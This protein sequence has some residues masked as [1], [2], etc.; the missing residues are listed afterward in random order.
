VKCV[1]VAVHAIT[2]HLQVIE[3][4]RLAA[5]EAAA[6]AAVRTPTFAVPYRVNSE[7]GWFDYQPLPAMYSAMLWNVCADERECASGRGNSAPA[8]LPACQIAQ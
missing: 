8:C 1:T 7:S 4:E 3:G 2:M 6:G 5:Y